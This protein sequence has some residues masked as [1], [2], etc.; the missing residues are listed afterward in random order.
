MS[1]SQQISAFTAALRSN[2]WLAWQETAVVAPN[3]PFTSELASTTRIENYPNFGPAPAMQEWD[4]SNDYGTVSDYVYSVENRLY[5]AS[6]LINK[7]NLD[8]DQTGVLASKPKELA[9]K[10]KKLKSREVMKC[11][12]SGVTGTF[13]DGTVYGP[14]FDGLNFFATRTGANGF[15]TGQPNLATYN[16]IAYNNGAGDT[17]T[18]Q[19]IAVYHGPGVEDLK[20]MFWQHRAG[21]DF[22]TNAGTDQ[23]D[24]SLQCRMWATMRG[25]AGY[26]YWMHVSRQFINGLPNQ[27]E[28]HNIFSLM[29]AGFRS[30]QLPKS[31]STS[32]GEYV[33]E[34]S[35]FNAGNLTVCGDTALSEVLRTALDNDWSA[36]NIGTSSTNTN[37]VATTN[38][39]KGWG[40]RLISSYLNSPSS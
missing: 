33:H 17:S 27:A 3:D 18:H 16:T 30:Y 31:R 13:S 2:F 6:L 26:G 40:R 10:A 21:P 5:R 25:R 11:L 22:R 35:D 32:F 24:E 39:F 23:E 20:P 7:L 12:A 9:I 4:G 15:G 28:V 29:E 38:R 1:V 8:D 19:I 36:Q 14:S 34:Q 37:T